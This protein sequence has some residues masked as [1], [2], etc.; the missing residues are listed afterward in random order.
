MM[1]PPF[2]LPTHVNEQ[3]GG[4]ASSLCNTSYSSGSNWNMFEIKETT[5]NTGVKSL[6]V[7]KLA[8]IA[9]S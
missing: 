4:D 7:A 3:Y 1:K 8:S 6:M 9:S 2:T 5:D